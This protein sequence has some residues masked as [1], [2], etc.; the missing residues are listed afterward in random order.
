MT[1]ADCYLQ[2]VICNRLYCK[3]LSLLRHTVYYAL[4]FTLLDKTETCVEQ[5]N[6]SSDFSANR[7][8]GPKSTDSWVIKF[9]PRIPDTLNVEKYE[10]RCRERFFFIE[11]DKSDQ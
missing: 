8:N 6:L 9:V 10:C 7:V 2:A 11:S 5:V 1:C 3:Y 4:H